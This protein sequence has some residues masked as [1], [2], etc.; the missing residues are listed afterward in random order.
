MIRLLSNNGLI[1][2]NICRF[3]LDLEFS[4]EFYNGELTR[5]EAKKKA[6]VWL[7]DEE[8][9][10]MRL[11]AVFNKKHLLGN[12]YRY[13]TNEIV[14]AYG[15]V[16]KVDERKAIPYLLQSSFIDLFHRQVLKVHKFLE[17]RKTFIPFMIH[18]CLYL[19]M[20]ANEKH[21]IND[22]V[23]VF[24]NTEYGNFKVKVMAGKKLSDMKELKLNG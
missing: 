23:S 12:H 7:Y 11:E 8:Q 15:R 19:D 18:D 4:N 13:D 1:A 2:S 16:I 20:C 3:S 22:I 17:S 24:S 9:K 21:L 10:D 5:A 14:T 6:I